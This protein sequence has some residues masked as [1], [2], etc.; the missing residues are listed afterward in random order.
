METGSDNVC[1]LIDELQAKGKQKSVEEI[2][3]FIFLCMAPSASG[4]R[5]V[6][7]MSYSIWIFFCDRS[8]ETEGKQGGDR[9]R[10][11][12]GDG[13]RLDLILSPHGPLL[14]YGAGRQSHPLQSGV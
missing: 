1:L 14:A 10:M 2:V 4:S 8:V 12:L 6:T 5:N 7:V 11:E 13:C 3:V 9:E